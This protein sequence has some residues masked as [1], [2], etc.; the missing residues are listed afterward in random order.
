MRSSHDCSA[1]IIIPLVPGYP[2]PLDSPDAG[3]V[4]MIMECQNCSMFRGEKSIFGRL[5]RE[6]ISPE[7]YIAFFSL[8]SWGKFKSGLLATQDVS[9]FLFDGEKK[10]S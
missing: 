9:V 3:S 1:I 7:Q 6:G 10:S 8:R 4:R 5:R 2:M